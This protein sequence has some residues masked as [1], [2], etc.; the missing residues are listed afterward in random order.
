MISYQFAQLFYM[1][2]ATSHEVATIGIAMWVPKSKRLLTFITRHYGRLSAFWVDFERSGY[3]QMIKYIRSHFEKIEQKINNVQQPIFINSDSD[4]FKQ[5]LKTLVIDEGACFK[6]SKIMAGVTKDVDCRFSQLRDELIE[7]HENKARKRI[8]DKDISHIVERCLDRNMI[9]DKVDKDII[10]TGASYE[11]K[12]K[13]GWKNGVRNV[14]EPLSLDYLEGR[15]MVER[16]NSWSGRLYSLSRNTTTPFKMI[17]VLSNP[18]PTN[19]P[20][21]RNGYEKAKDILNNAPNM[22]QIVSEREVDSLIS[23]IQRE[24]EA[25]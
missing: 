12:F 2:D 22:R 15:D 14:I 9:L 5:I 19:Q 3:S 21:L 1:H 24:I 8:E 20:D 4:N 6:W 25:A 10:I 18:P 11:Y 7:R 16:A 23:T 13:F 17:G